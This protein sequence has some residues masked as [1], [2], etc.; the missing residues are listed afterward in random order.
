MEYLAKLSV[1]IWCFCFI[2]VD[3]LFIVAPI[4]VGL[5]VLSL[6]FGG[7]PSILSNSAFISLRKRERAGLFLKFLLL[8]LISYGC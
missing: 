2:F 4:F 3:L 7:V 1:F 5:C 6:F 8:L